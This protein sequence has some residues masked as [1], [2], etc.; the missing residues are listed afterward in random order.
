MSFEQKYLKYK[1]KYNK[2]KYLIGGDNCPTL[3]DGFNQKY[4]ECWHDT[5][6]MILIYNNFT[7][8]QIKKKILS[9]KENSDILIFITSEQNK[10]KFLLPINFLNSELFII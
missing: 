9:F 4:N 8:Q 1:N 3:N 2:M 5:T 10:N 7:L 6:L